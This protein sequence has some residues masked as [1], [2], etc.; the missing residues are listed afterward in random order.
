MASTATFVTSAGSRLGRE[1]T[2][3]GP[4]DARP[5][6]HNGCQLRRRSSRV[7]AELDRKLRHFEW[8]AVFVLDGVTG[9]QGG[10]G[11]RLAGVVNGPRW[12]LSNQ[13]RWVTVCGGRLTTSA[14]RERRARG[15]GPGRAFADFAL[16]LCLQRGS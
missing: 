15:A 11:S 3:Q 4:A 10:S 6:P 13:K 12:A 7:E 16:A 1:S 9:S 2:V 8:E 14:G 5:R